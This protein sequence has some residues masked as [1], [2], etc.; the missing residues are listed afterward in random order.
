MMVVV[1][2]PNFVVL[3]FSQNG[4]YLSSRELPMSDSMLQASKQPNFAYFLL[5]NI[6]GELDSF[7]EESGFDEQ[8]ITVKR[9]FD[10]VHHIGIE[11]FPS[12][13]KEI[14]L[15]PQKFNED[16]RAGAQAVRN[17][18]SAEGVFVL[19]TNAH[20]DYW[21]EADGEISAS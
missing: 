10:N 9:F 20:T 21:L 18:W 4:D 14:L 3:T 15:D 1:Q 12:Y 8:T 2:V 19:F 17:R 13:A 7:L 16:E 5:E 11:D 6:E